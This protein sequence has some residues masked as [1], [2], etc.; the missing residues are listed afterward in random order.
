MKE[1]IEAL[2]KRVDSLD[3]VK[4]DLVNKSDADLFV[5]LQAMYQSLKVAM[6][7][8]GMNLQ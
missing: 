3:K 7:R 1:T 4:L 8:Q 5:Q 2:S 6:Q